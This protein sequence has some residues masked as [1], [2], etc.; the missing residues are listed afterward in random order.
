M[1]RCMLPLIQLL[2]TTCLTVHP[3]L[4]LQ[5]HLHSHMLLLLFILLLCGVLVVPVVQ[6]LLQVRQRHAV[7]SSTCV[8]GKAWIEGACKA[9]CPCCLC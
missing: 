6:R 8:G 2:H 7:G 4:T 3:C 5:L 1:L 9:G